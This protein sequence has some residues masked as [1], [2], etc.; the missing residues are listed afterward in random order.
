MVINKKN[1]F[2]MLKSEIELDPLLIRLLAN[3]GIRTGEEASLFL[4][5]TLYD[6]EDGRIMKD[7]KKGVNIVKE[8]IEK[9]EKIIIY[10]DYDCD[11][12]CSTTILY[13][14]LE[15]LGAQF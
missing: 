4:N 9:Q 5:G 6:L 8:G 7:M 11:G 3:R 14:T 12:V 10:G 13:K 15:S 1:E 2:E